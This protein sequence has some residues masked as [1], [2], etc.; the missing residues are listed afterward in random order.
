M[1]K[2]TETPT[3]DDRT[4]M[5]EIHALRR[6]LAYAEGVAAEHRLWLTTQLIGAAVESLESIGSEGACSSPE[7]GE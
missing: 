4:I 1:P 2:P 3:E 5:K 6:L 7:A